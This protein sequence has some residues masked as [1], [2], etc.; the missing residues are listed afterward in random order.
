M[1]GDFDCA[2]AGAGRAGYVN[3]AM[4]IGHAVKNG[5]WCGSWGRC[6]HAKNS[7][8]IGRNTFSEEQRSDPRDPRDPVHP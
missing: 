6:S 1:R 2:V 3:A 4:P 8:I 7:R 5:Y